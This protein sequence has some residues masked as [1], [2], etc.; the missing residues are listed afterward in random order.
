MGVPDSFGTK[1]GGNLS[2]KF[3]FYLS[4]Q[5]YSFKFLVYTT[6]IF[7][8]Q[9]TTRIHFTSLSSIS[10]LNESLKTKETR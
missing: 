1:V 4:L 3:R 10:R 9:V 6:S 8:I 7:L 5:E 2:G